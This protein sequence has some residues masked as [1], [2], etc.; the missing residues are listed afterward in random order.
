MLG[1]GPSTAAIVAAA[2]T[3]NIPVIRLNDGNLVQL[4]YGARQR[5]IWS[6]ETDRTGTVAE[7]ISRDKDLT[8]TLLAAAGI[9]IPAGRRV[10]SA[11]D[12]RDAASE[13]GL[14]VVIK[15]LDG[16]NGRGVFLG[17]ASLEEIDAAHAA[18]AGEGR[19]VIVERHIP[20]EEH[21]LLVVGS[22]LVAA[23]KGEIVEIVGDG[24]H[25]ILELIE[26]QIN[27]DPRRG[28]D[29][30]APAAV[31]RIDQAT[32]LNLAR[33]GLAPDSRPADHLRVM[34]QSRGN[35]SIDVTD[36]V[37]PDVA[38][39]AELAARVVGLDIAGIDLVTTDIGRPLGEVGGAI[40]EVN[41]RPDLLPHLCP[42]KGAARPVGEAIVDHLFPG[43]G[44]G[45]IA[46]VGIAPS[47]GRAD[48]GEILSGIL[49]QGERRV[50]RASSRGLFLGA[51]LVDAARADNQAG[52]RRI[53]QNPAVDIAV[54]ESGPHT[55]HQEGL[56]YDGCLVGVVTDLEADQASDGARLQIEAVLPMGAAVLD[57]DNPRAAD[58]ARFCRGE[59]IFFTRHPSSPV[60]RA[61]LA[62]GKR[63]VSIGRRHLRFHTGRSSV[64]GPVIDGVHPA[65]A[66]ATAAIAAAWILGLSP[67]LISAALA[68]RTA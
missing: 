5:W 47:G 68:S 62:A 66:A 60:M 3:R 25:T 8:K 44:N 15:P 46:V 21:R 40:V 57:A 58:M 41:A 11:S 31:V 64:A 10:D 12:A 17:L 51:R 36:Q 55:P 14:P 28:D 2:R 67:Q 7:G 43:D 61:H 19:S 34:I 38:R 54:I 45:R 16:N 4:G 29:P 63:A 27:A 20:G 39:Q 56:A 6:A 30:F 32:L 35:L 18:A 23:A 13:L 49:G 33:Q 59:V 22:R 53:L 9:P 42:A 52:G 26:S 65:P 37:H 24:A 1:L 50:G 48:V